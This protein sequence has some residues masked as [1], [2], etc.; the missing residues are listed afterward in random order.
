MSKKIIKVPE[1]VT[2][3]KFSEILGLPVTSIMAE[4]MK[5]GIMATINE[6]IDFETASIIASDLG[7]DIQ[8]DL[9]VDD[10]EIITLEKLLDI[11]K[12]EKDS[13]EKLVNRPPIVTILGHV[14]HGKTTL[15]DAIRKT[16][17]VE[18]ESGGITQHITAY[19]VKKKG[20]TI[21]FIDTPG[22][23]AFASMRERGVSIADIAILVVAAD[24]GV[25]PQTKEVIEYLKDRNIPIIVAINKIDKDNANLDR[26]KKDLYENGIVIEE[27]GGDVLCN[28]VSAKNNIGINKLLDSILL[29][30]EVEEFK[31]S[32]D[33]NGLAVVL[34]SH[35]DPRK[36]PIATVLIKTGV[37]KVGQDVIVG[38]VYGRIRRMEDYSGRSM[39]K[40]T[41]STP[42][43]IFGLNSVVKTNDIV[44]VVDAKKMARLKVKNADRFSNSKK[45]I[46]SIS[47]NLD[48][49][50]LNIIIKFDVQGSME[51]IEQLLRD[52]PQNKVAINYVNT[53]VGNITE[54][55]IKLAV[56]SES[57][58][59][60]F[61]VDVN[62]VARRLAENNNIEIK[63][64]DVVYRLVDDIKDNLI[65][66]LPEEIERTDYGEL[67]VL[68]V[69]FTEKNHMIVGGKVLDGKVLKDTEIDVY[70]GDKLIGSGKLGNLQ[71]NKISVNEVEKGN[72][73]GITFEGDTKIK[74]GDKL[75]FYTQVVKEKK[76]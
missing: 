29:V 44:Q 57:I 8:E 73:C 33:R 54:S 2:V 16:Q 71:Q 58:V 39:K 34:E 21:T 51:A 14:D 1:V 60:G 50:K 52:I 70:R 36:G 72:E 40:A 26:V 41:P 68:G 59:Y 27:W 75:K 22:H 61:N 64:Y 20:K 11:C 15:L 30:A 17:V 19:Q 42:V 18:G 53:D 35:K 28:E 4:L 12:K 46:K 55:D 10:K 63:T 13:G 69:F 6:E 66:L 74:L 45:N 56:S 65:E 62:A 76:L 48:I 38:G 9:N 31:A 25:K 32:E 49:P 24:D 47:D 43:T 5:N 37:L 23:E 3:K 7:F 67:E